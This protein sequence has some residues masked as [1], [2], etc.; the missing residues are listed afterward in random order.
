MTVWR[1][2]P[3]LGLVSLGDA[4]GWPAAV[5]LQLAAFGAFALGT[6]RI[7]RGRGAR[8]TP[9][10]PRKGWRRF[11]RGPWPLLAGGVALAT[12]NAAT[13]VVS[14][15]P[16]GIT[17]A[18]AL[19]GAKALQA[20]GF[21]L[22]TVPFWQQP[23]QRA[24]LEAPVLADVTTVMNLGVLLG[25]LLGAG[26]AGR[27]KPARR[28]PGRV[29]VASLLGGLLMGYGAR[30][31]FGCNIGAYFSGIASTS[32]HGW[33]WVVAAL[34][35]TPLA[36]ALRARLTPERRGRPPALPPR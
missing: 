11:L 34:F 35:V 13:L 19:W 29:V 5:A 30:L 2:A 32:L 8:P 28:V 27:F 7:E 17:F 1:A 4:L 36:V 20:L 15:S 21:D 25:A 22:S 31:S 33:L 6:R 16:W 9:P 24:S 3:S 14:G 10:P 23:F 12:L 26:L 18:F